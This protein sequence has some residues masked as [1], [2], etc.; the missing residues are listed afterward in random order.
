MPANYRCLNTG[1]CEKADRQEVIDLPEGVDP[2]CPGCGTQLTLAR[3]PEKQAHT[4]SCVVVSVL[5][6]LLGAFSFYV[7]KS[8]LGPPTPPTSPAPAPTIPLAAETPTATTSLATATP[9]PT[10]PLI[11]ETPAPT[12]PLVAA[13]P[14]AAVVLRIHGSNTIGSKLVPSLVDGFL[15]QQG[16]TGMHIATG[17]NPDES[18]VEATIP[19]ELSRNALKSLRMAPRQLLPICRLPGATSAWL[20]GKSKPT[21]QNPV[22]SP[23]WAI[24]I[25][26]LANMCLAWMGSPLSSTTLTRSTR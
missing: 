4:V 26:P 12:T 10:T 23:A 16:A 7:I 9:A 18:E 24:C 6:L 5:L 2:V 8:L 19:G 22:E 1:N 25:R 15:K 17:K 13:T 21:K 14:V 11:A 3:P 20:R